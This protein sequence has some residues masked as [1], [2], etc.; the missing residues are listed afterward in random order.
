M[1]ANVVGIGEKRSGIG[2]KSGK[3]YDGMSIYV[4]TNEPDVQGQ[5]AEEVYFNF[6]SRVTFPTINVGDVID[7]G[8]GKDGFIKSVD[9][10]K[11]AKA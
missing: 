2:K 8:Y 11:P 5:K 10:L 3:P 7:I 4:L 1:K 6:L 9:V